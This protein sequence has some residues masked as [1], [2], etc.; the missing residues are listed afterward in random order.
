MAAKKTSKTTKTK[1]PVAK[2]RDM[3]ELVD[4]TAEAV[5][6]LTKPREGFEEHAEPLFEL[7]TTRKAALGQLAISVD[8]ARERLV[9]YKALSADE[10]A[11]RADLEVAA[12]RLE[13][14]VETRA[15]QASKVWSVMLD[16]YGKGKQ[17]GKSDA[18]IAAEIKPF[19]SFMSVGPRNKDG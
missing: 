18:Q 4:L 19:V 10:A 15:L 12:K 11:A 14:V 6:A 2:T 13:M 17:A 3:T 8:E 7:W 1:K 5:R 9:R 16:I